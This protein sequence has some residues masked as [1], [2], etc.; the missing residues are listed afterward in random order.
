MPVPIERLCGFDSYRTKSDSCPSVKH[1]ALIYTLTWAVPIFPIRQNT[2]TLTDTIFNHRLQS[3]YQLENLG[4]K[5]TSYMRC[6]FLADFI[7]VL[8]QA[9][10]GLI[11]VKEC[12]C[13]ITITKHSSASILRRAASGSLTVCAAFPHQAP[14][15]LVKHDL[16]Y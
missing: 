9:E 11:L 7:G 4:A 1:S 15:Y 3:W 13:N 16:F 8:S 14:N 12:S 2:Q 6:S 5:P 10:Q